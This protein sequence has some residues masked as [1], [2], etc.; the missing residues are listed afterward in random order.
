MTVQRI[1]IGLCLLLYIS[2]GLHWLL[3]LCLRAKQ[4]APTLMGYDV[5]I[6]EEEECDHAWECVARGYSCCI[7]CGLEKSR[8]CDDDADN[9]PVDR[10][11]V[12]PAVLPRAGGSPFNDHRIAVSGQPENG[13]DKRTGNSISEDA[14]FI[15]IGIKP[16]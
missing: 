16:K 14:T 5:P 13:A 10:L 1:I 7:H 2:Y 8:D 4:P 11:S 3:S 15:F 9:F 12:A 6:I